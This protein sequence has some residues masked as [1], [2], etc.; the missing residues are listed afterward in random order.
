MC[1]AGAQPRAAS[2]TAP[3][4]AELTRRAYFASRPRSAFGG[5]GVHARSRRSIVSCE[6]A[7]LDRLAH[8]VDDDRV[9]VLDDRD[10]AADGGF[11]RH[12]ADDEAVA[13]AGEPA[14]RDQRDL[15]AETAADD[16]AGRAQ[17]LGHARRALRPFVAN[18]DDV[19]G[20][21]DAVD[22]RAQRVVLAVEHARAALE[23][24]AFL[25]RD[26]RDGAFGREVAVEHGEMAVGL[27]RIVERPNDRLARPDTAARPRG[28]RRPC[29]P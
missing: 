4:D 21:D 26:L 16:G 27:D 7:E 2:V 15:A 9:A 10:R 25:A 23:P 14:V 19:A 13:A 28:S 22:D 24:R 17:H 12:V 8:G 29:G 20:H 1:L 18:H 11:G 5:G 3:S 6:H